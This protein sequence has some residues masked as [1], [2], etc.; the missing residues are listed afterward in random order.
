MKEMFGWLGHVLRMKV[1][2]LSK[3]VLSGYPTGAKDKQVFPEWM[4]SKERI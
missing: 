1:D 4:R 2:R 3:I